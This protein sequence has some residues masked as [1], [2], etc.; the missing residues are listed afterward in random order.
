MEDYF[1]GWKSVTSGV[2][3][4][5][6]L[7]PRLFIMYVNNLDENVSSKINKVA[8]DTK[9]GGVVDSEDGYVR[10]QQDLDQL[11]K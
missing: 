10:F 11:R 8:D 7:G 1:S 9:I 4:G 2:P 3:Y 5:S 6:M